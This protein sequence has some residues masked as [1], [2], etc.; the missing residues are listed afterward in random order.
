MSRNFDRLCL[1]ITI[2][3]HSKQHEGFSCQAFST[4][5]TDGAKCMVDQVELGACE[6]TSRAYVEPGELGQVRYEWFEI[7]CKASSAC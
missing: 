5:I 1:V 2:C 6:S 7:D 4:E 3:C